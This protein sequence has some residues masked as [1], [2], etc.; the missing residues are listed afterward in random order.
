MRLEQ[1]FW[2]AFEDIVRR[3]DISINSLVSRI[4]TASPDGVNLSGAI[5]VFVLRY[6]WALANG[7]TPRVPPGST[8]R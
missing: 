8:E 1:P 4:W 3:E 6:F 2:D 7:R 5:R